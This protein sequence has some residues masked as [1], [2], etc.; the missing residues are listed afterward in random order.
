MYIG[1]AI[2]NTAFVEVYK[3]GLS[4]LFYFTQQSQDLLE[5][6]LSKQLN[7][8]VIMSTYKTFA[9]AGFGT[10][11]ALFAKHFAQNKE[12]D[13][14]WKVLSRSV[15][16]P[17]LQDAA[18]QGAELA[19]VDYDSQASLINALQGVD[20]VLSALRDEGLEEVQLNLVRAAKAAGVKLFV[21]SEYGRST[22]GT[23]EPYLISKAN[24]HALLKALNLPYAL[25]F[26]GIW[27]I[28][29]LEPAYGSATGI[30]FDA[31][32]FSLFGD[33]TEPLSWTAP[34]DFVPF[35]Y[36]VLTTLQPS[37]LEN[38]V[39]QIE[40]DRKSFKQIIALWE[41]KTGR[42]AVIH[43]RSEEEIQ[44][45]INAQEMELLR[46]IP[47]QWQLGGMRVS[48]ESNRLWPEWNPKNSKWEDLF[49]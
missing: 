19:A 38:A 31:G 3:G 29:I 42:K 25:F 39:F 12:N 4:I 49:A 36:Q 41:K 7:F 27:P 8:L 2:D 20:V 45:Y 11:G 43:E 26:T 47:R 35:V 6:R 5:Q 17:E 37:Q 30:D 23:T 44:A 10:T 9:I 48:G 28:M 33:G 13:L 46:F 32:K 22:L 15:T 14:K 18:S 16:K 1:I 24:T 40:G 21:P 34:Q